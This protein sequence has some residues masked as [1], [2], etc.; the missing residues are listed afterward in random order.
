MRIIIYIDSVELALWLLKYSWQACKFAISV[1][2]RM[3]HFI[4]YLALI[5][6][7]TCMLR[8]SPP[9]HTHTDTEDKIG[10]CVPGRKNISVV[11]F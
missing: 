5:F 1:Y 2:I 10:S 7:L 6:S 4:K 11:L 8:L 9:R 3:C